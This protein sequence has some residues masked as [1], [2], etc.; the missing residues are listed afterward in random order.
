M[1]IVDFD[2][3]VHIFLVRVVNI[4]VLAFILVLVILARSFFVLRFVSAQFELYHKL[5]FIINLDVI[6]PGS[7]MFFDAYAS[8]LNFA[9]LKLEASKVVKL[10][11]HHENQTGD[12]DY[13]HGQDNLENTCKEGVM[14]SVGLKSCFAFVK[15][16]LLIL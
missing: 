16:A 12:N 14:S 3:V 2:L 4:A 7:L 15:K 1:L 10:T 11:F 5:I 13:Q 9:T 8:G 6:K